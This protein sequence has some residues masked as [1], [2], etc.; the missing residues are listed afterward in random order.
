LRIVG[1]D[2]VCHLRFTI[3]SAF[4][5]KSAHQKNDEAYQQNQTDTASTDSGTSE[6]KTAA[7]EQEE[8]D[9]YKEQ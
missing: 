4:R 7:T 1:S 3:Q 9:D 8:K 2:A 5:P 6:V